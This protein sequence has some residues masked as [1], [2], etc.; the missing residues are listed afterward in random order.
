M[1]AKKEKI[2]S[3]KRFG[4]RYGTR[5]KRKVDKLEQQYKYGQKC[6]YCNYKKVK[7]LSLGIWNCSKC[8]S[9]FTGRAYS[10]KEEIKVEQ[11]LK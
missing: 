1:P 4:A 6:P 7:R 9:K 8:Y 11:T 3:T 5:N 2:K 10:V